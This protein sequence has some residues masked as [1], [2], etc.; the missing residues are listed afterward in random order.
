MHLDYQTS[1]Y[2]GKVYKF[3]HIAESYRDGGKVKKNRLFPLGKLTDEQAQKIRLVLRVVSNPD[4]QVTTLSNIVAQE[5]VN[6]LDVAVVNKLWETWQLSDAFTFN[7]TRGDLSTDLVAKI[8]TINRCLDPCSHYSVPQWI[9]KTALPDILGEQI[10]H[11]NDDKIYYE[12]SK[13][14]KNKPAIEYFLFEKTYKQDPK[15]YDYVNYDLSSSYFVGF[16]CKLS[17]FGRSKD[18][19]PNCKQVILAL[20]INSRGYPFNWDVFPGNLPEIETMDKIIKSCAHRFKLENVSMV[21]DRGLVS[22]DNLDLIEDKNLKYITA[23]DRDQIPNI[24]NIDLQVFKDL[25]SDNALECIPQL[26]G[27]SQFD[28]SLYYHDLGVDRKRRYVV[29]INPERFIQDRKTR[30][31]KM[32]CFRRFLVQTNRS[33]KKAK[34]DRMATPTRNKFFNELKRLKIKKYYEDPQLKEIYVNV[35]LKGGTQKQV[36]SFQVTVK[37]KKQKIAKE[38]LTDGLCVF[39]TNHIEKQQDRYRVSAKRIIGVYR[40]KT[41]VEDAFKHIKSFVKIRPFFVNTDEHVKAVYTICVLSYFIN[42]YLS[43]KRRESEGKDY[44]N[45]KQLYAPFKSCKLVTLL[46]TLAGITKKDIV[47]F[48]DEQKAILGNI[49]SEKSI[50][51]KPIYSSTKECSP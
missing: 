3:Y 51:F 19:K 49:V 10:L 15:S 17:A 32:D 42:R 43:D 44:L 20:M 25:D 37:E 31:D 29:G 30:K 47:P 41:Q 1:K 28:A 13:I 38:K 46:E 27:F 39:V 50:K 26:A 34:R 36:R 21:F 5:C 2:K 6:Y 11:L 7:V 8:L 24:A 18:G 35:T 12:L 45:S 40:Q 23:L 16:K 4:E 48:S 9:R 22:D 33:L 14:E